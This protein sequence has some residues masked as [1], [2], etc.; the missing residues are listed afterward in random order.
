MNGEPARNPASTIPDVHGSVDTRELA[1]NKVGIKDIRHPVIVKDRSDGKQHTI[2]TFSMFV[3]LPHQFKGTHMSR[4]VKILNDHEKEISYTSFNEMLKE[5]AELLEAESGYIEMSFPYFVNKKAPVSMVESL[6]D[7]E[8]S[9]IGQALEEIGSDAEPYAIFLQSLPYNFYPLLAL[10]FGI[11]VALTRRDFG[12]MLKAERRAA[13]GQVLGD[14]A[15]PLADFGGESLAPIEGQPRRWINAAI[16]VGLVLVV[17][18]VAL[19]ITGRSSLVADGHAAGTTGLFSLGVEGFGAVFSA[20]ASYNALMYAAIAGSASALILAVGQRIFPL[21]TG[22]AAWIDG[23][24]SMMPAMVI[25]I[26]AWG[27]GNVCSDLH[28]ADF[29]V[30]Q[31]GDSL[32]PGFLPA[33]VFSLAAVTAF[34]TG[35]SWATMSILIPLAVPTAVGVSQG[36]GWDPGATHAIML[37]AVSSVLA[38]ALFGDHCSPISDTTVMSSMASGCDHVD[39]VRTQ[40]PYALAVA[41][42]ALV[43]G[44][45]PVGFG[46]SPWLGLLLG[47]G[48]LYAF[49][50]FVGRRS[51]E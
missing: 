37:A 11:M 15:V 50:R 7:Y 39:H 35:T 5:M 2:A 1:I 45:L 24:K 36:A 40:L 46:L 44:Y 34:A 47:V 13:G 10:A 32:N 41:V 17:T 20:G 21:A 28:T 26:L 22:L 30:A 48:V 42:V 9:L 19:W 14:G 25:L 33:L 27:I 38:G 4:F 16:P 49:L 8:V 3:F 43:V 23:M 18:F 31:L 12:P 6:L 51:P 29:L